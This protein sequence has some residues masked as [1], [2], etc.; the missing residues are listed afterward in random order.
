MCVITSH[1]LL[2]DYP[3][4]FQPFLHE[5]HIYLPSFSF[6]DLKAKTVE[7]VQTDQLKELEDR[8]KALDDEEQHAVEQK[9]AV[10]EQ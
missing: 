2:I 4:T 7:A 5:L 10:A 1:D 3:I 8:L 9:Q 6:V